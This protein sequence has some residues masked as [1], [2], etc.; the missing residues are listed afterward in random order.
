MSTTKSRLRAD[1]KPALEKSGHGTIRRQVLRLIRDVLG[2]TAVEETV[3]SGLLQ[4]LAEHPGDPELAL[5]VHLSDWQD[6]E[7][8]TLLDHFARRPE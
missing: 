5:L 3:R 1:R 8:Q 7:D 2:D 6:R 4:H